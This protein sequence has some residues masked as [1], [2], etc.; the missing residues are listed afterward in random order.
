MK[1]ILMISHDASLTG[2][3][4]SILLISKILENQGYNI[5]WIVGKSGP[6]SA[7]FERNTTDYWQVDLS[8]AS[9]KEKILF[10]VKGGVVKHRI[11]IV[12]GIKKWRPNLIINNTVVNGEIVEQ[13]SSLG[14]PI[15]SR[16]PEM[17]SVMMYYDQ[18][19]NSTSKVFQFSD[20]IVAASD[21]VMDHIINLWNVEKEKVRSFYTGTDIEAL[22]LK[23]DNVFTVSACG[24]LVSRKGMESFLLTA[25]KTAEKL[26]RSKLKFQWIGGRIGDLNYYEFLEDVRKL[27][28]EDVVEVTGLV[29]D[30]RP[31]LQSTDVFLMVSK[32]DPFPLVTL[33]AI[34][35]GIPFV[36]FD[37]S[38]GATDLAKE[39][40]GITVPFLDIE[41]MSN[42]LVLWLDDDKRLEAGRK[43]KEVSSYY[44]S[45]RVEKDWIPL[46]QSIIN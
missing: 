42:Q 18:V 32:E 8:N 44:K 11:R 35:H 43:A 6:R 31:F 10:R 27:G 7:D 13:F 46:V 33:E 22:P 34:A 39:G 30:V 5:R 9:F 1:R 25:K 2:A 19:D 37:H 3:P 23:K 40:A 36:C 20:Q 21:S 14:I 4:K 45:D 15:I 41:A 17:H 29:T 26:D 28:L 24:S 16:I 12:N 38:G